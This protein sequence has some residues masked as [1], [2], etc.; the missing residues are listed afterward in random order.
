MIKLYTIKYTY[1]VLSVLTSWLQPCLPPTC[2]LSCRYRCCCIYIRYLSKLSSVLLEE[3]PLLCSLLVLLHQTF[4]L[5]LQLLGVTQNLILQGDAVTTVM[6]LDKVIDQ[7][8]LSLHTL[9]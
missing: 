4:Q 3:H 6:D 7:S 1:I 9:K 8:C 2:Q 5:L